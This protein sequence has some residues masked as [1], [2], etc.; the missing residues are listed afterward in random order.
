MGGDFVFRESGVLVDVQPDLDS[1]SKSGYIDEILPTEIQNLYSQGPKV[2]DEAFSLGQRS[3]AMKGGRHMKVVKTMAMA[4]VVVSLSLV[5]SEAGV[6]RVE[7][8]SR[9]EVAGGQSF[10][11]AGPYERIEGKV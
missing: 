2:G 10:G 3:R 1:L 9:T 8:V 6:V 4:A 7:V 11:L 5:D